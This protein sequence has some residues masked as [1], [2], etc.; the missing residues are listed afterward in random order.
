MT[1][2]SDMPLWSSVWLKQLAI[3]FD[4]IAKPS[5]E[6][7]A[8]ISSATAVIGFAG[9]FDDPDLGVYLRCAALGFALWLIART[10]WAGAWLLPALEA[11]RSIIVYVLVAVLGFSM[12]G[13]VSVIGS[14]SATG[15]EISEGLTEN[16]NIDQLDNASQDFAFYVGELTVVGGA[17]E[18]QAAQAQRSQGAEVSGNGPTGVPGVGSVS[19][20]FGEAARIYGQAALSLIQTLNKAQSHIA[21]IDAALTNMR[22]VQSDTQ[23]S[24]ADKA[25]RLKDLSRSAIGEMRGLLSLDPARSIK[26]AANSIAAGVA[27]RSNTNPRSAARIAEISVSMRTFAAGLVIEA[28][29]IASLVPDLPEQMTLSPAEKLLATMWRMPGLT[30]A[31]LLM[32]ACG[33]IAIGFRM[34]VYLALKAKI[35]EETARPV[36][37][38]VTLEEFWRVEEFVARAAEAKK[39]VEDAR[40]AP[41]RGRPPLTKAQRLPKPRSA[42]KTMAKPG[43]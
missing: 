16:A 34:S 25:A 8:I 39:R 28:D 42:P 17:L 7:L 19:N 32:D 1:P 20:S 24:R 15:S 27:T 41:K 14:L 36:P 26:A 3:W 9:Q 38:F 35:A 5:L 12:F 29:R 2:S 37:N 18:A 13:S 6:G 11:K 43:K 40:G 30:L 21:K 33:W 23:L 31:A 4:S 22:V 10:F